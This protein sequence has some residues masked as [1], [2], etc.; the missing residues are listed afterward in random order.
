MDR[1]T[2][3][4]SITVMR[5]AFPLSRDRSRVGV[6]RKRANVAEHR[7]GKQSHEEPA[8]QAGN[9]HEACLDYPAIQA[10]VKNTAPNHGAL[11]LR[12]FDLDA[13]KAVALLERSPQ[14]GA[15]PPKL[16]SRTR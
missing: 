2:V 12:R 6:E 4:V 10:H 3:G 13:R 8:G 9:S 15:H 7:E 16:H 11:P 1:I 5:R 14:P